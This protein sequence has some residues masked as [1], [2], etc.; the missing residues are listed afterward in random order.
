MANTDIFDD[1]FNIADEDVPM[2]IEEETDEITL[3][4]VKQQLH[5]THKANGWDV[6]NKERSTDGFYNEIVCEF[7]EAYEQAKEDKFDIYF[8]GDKPEG[9]LIELADTVT[10]ILNS[11]SDWKIDLDPMPE[12]SSHCSFTGRPSIDQI[13]SFYRETLMYVLH[14]FANVNDTKRIIAAIFTYCKARGADLISAI[15][16]KDQYNQTRGHMHGGKRF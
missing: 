6:A 4:A 7:M 13:D 16:L 10:R 3:I 1:R 2:L 15:L 11:L 9:E 14:K 5:K 8:N 12:S